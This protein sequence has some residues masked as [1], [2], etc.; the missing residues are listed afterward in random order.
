MLDK[1][2]SFDQLLEVLAD[3]YVQDL[4]RCFKLQIQKN[5]S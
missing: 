1:E 5:K 4:M 3:D 2:F